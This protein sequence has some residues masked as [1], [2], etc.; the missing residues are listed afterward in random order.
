MHTTRRTFLITSLGLPLAAVRSAPWVLSR[1]PG[2]LLVLGGTRFLGPPIVRAAQAAGCEVTL[3]NRGRSNPGL[4]KDL[5]Q[6]EG[7]RDTGNLEALKGRRFDAVV[8]TS[9]YAPRHV[10][11]AC[12]LLRE[13]VQHYVFVSTVSVYPDQS[14]A[15]VDEQTATSQPTAEAIAAAATIREASAQY[16]PMKAE[17]ERTAERIM[18]GRVTIVRPGLIVGPEDTSDRFTYW[19]VRIA[20]G[21]EVLAPGDRDAEVQFVDVRDLGA[22]C[23]ALAAARTAGTFNAVGFRGR[24][25]MGDLLGGCKV[26]LNTEAALTWVDDAFLKANKVRA[27]TEMPLWLPQG[28]RGHF[29]NKKAVAAGL[30]FR[31]VAE[32]IRDTVEWHRT[33]PADYKLRA[34]LAAEREAELLRAWAGRAR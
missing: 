4:F 25:S 14:A 18:P 22:W 5:E 12:E 29:D 23:F 32:T 31:P 13:N 20:R 30:A 6:L 11:Q 17:C 9:G 19:P 8:D 2:K 7:D 16:G 28:Q 24:L 34:G 33:R 15:V 27:Y 3:F 10:Q 21:G 26:T 1:R